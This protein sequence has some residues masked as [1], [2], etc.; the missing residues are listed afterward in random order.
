VESVVLDDGNLGRGTSQLAEAIAER[1]QRFIAAVTD[2][3]ATRR[4]NEIRRQRVATRT[5]AA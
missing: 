1:S 5:S 3:V 2:E 4:S